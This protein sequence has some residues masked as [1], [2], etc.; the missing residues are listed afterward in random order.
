MSGR[1]SEA[2]VACIRLELRV[3]V[4]GLSTLELDVDWNLDYPLVEVL[5]GFFIREIFIV[6][7]RLF[8]L[9]G[10]DSASLVK[11]GLES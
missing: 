2:I 1:Y 11:V 5:T 10:R 8:R 6:G 4:S 7:G 3:F 9:F